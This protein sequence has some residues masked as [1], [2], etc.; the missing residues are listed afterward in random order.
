MANM[1]FAYDFMFTNPR[2]RD[3]VSFSF[4]NTSRFDRVTPKVIQYIICLLIH[5]LHKN[6]KI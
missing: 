5:Y 2:Y 1:D 3:D 4:V 6:I